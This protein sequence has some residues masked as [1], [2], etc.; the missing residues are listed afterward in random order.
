MSA[1]IA[2]P[3][4]Q[5]IC[6]IPEVR[7]ALDKFAADAHEENMLAMVSAIMGN[8]IAQLHAVGPVAVGKI[9][10]ADEYGPTIEWHMHW[11]DL[12]GRL[13]YASRSPAVAQPVADDREQALR[14]LLELIGDVTKYRYQ[15]SYNDSYFGE[16]AGLLKRTVREIE[17][18]LARAALG[19][20]AE[21]GGK[22]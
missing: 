3:E 4:A 19:Q 18:L 15:M 20:P 16:P 5:R 6:D 13:L 8:A 10:G 12:I 1:P 17:K 21:E 22:S 2:W 14:R 11:A 9:P 7:E